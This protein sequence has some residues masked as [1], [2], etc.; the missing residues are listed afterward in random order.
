MTPDEIFDDHTLEKI[1]GVPD[2]W[3]CS[4]DNH[5]FDQ[6]IVLPEQCHVRALIA[7]MPQEILDNKRLREVEKAA[8]GLLEA[9]VEGQGGDRMEAAVKALQ[10]M[11]EDYRGDWWSEAR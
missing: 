10:N 8:K 5:Y 6:N 2:T 4:S 3:A 9:V 1:A 7:A 11:L